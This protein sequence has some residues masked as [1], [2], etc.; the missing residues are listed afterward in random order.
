MTGRNGKAIG[1]CAGYGEGQWNAALVITYGMG[2]GRHPHQCK[3]CDARVRRDRDVLTPS[4]SRVDTARVDTADDRPRTGIV[5]GIHQI[6]RR[7]NL[8]IEMILGALGAALAA[9]A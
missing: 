2:Y 6:G 9:A 5:A 3:A 1:V 8:R 7:E 4:G